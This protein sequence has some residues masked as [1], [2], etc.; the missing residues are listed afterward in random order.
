MTTALEF[1]TASMR[2][3]GALAAGE[4]PSGED[5]SDCFEALNAM[6]DAWRAESLMVYAYEMNEFPLVSGQREYTIGSGGDFDVPRPDVMPL[7]AKLRLNQS[8]EQDLPLAILTQ[9]QYAAIVLKETTSTLAGAMSMDGGYPLRTISIWPVPSQDNQALLLWLATVLEEFDGLSDDIVLPP[10][11]R[12][13]IIYNLALEIA[14][15]FGRDIPPAV[16]L[17]AMDSKAWVKR[18]NHQ[19]YKMQV[20]PVLTVRNGRY[21]IFTDGVV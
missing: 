13:A 17:I 15:E 12:K 18:A 5:A 4:T 1:I 6:I 11:Y 7:T 8:Q 10:G 16:G 21:N 9:Q 19:V 20:D 3:I 2:K 14:P